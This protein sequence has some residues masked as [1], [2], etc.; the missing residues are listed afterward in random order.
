[1]A[2]EIGH[3]TLGQRHPQPKGVLLRTEHARP[4][5]R[6][7]GRRALHPRRRCHHVLGRYNLLS[8]GGRPRGP[9]PRAASSDDSCARRH[10][11]IQ[12]RERRLTGP[13]RFQASTGPAPSPQ[14]PTSSNTLTSAVAVRSGCRNRRAVVRCRRPCRRRG[15]SWG[16]GRGSC[17]LGRSAWWCEGSAWRGWVCA[18]RR[19]TP[20]SSIVVTNVAQHVR[21]H[22]R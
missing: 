16:V 10:H 7:R 2:L 20:A 15:G 12:P 21:M 18:S 1:M 6:A 19:S 8:R 3:L 17:G 22:R 4:L 9:P 13:E 11:S 5:A 14:S